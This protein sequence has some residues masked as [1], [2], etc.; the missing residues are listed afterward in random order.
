LHLVEEAWHGALVAA[1]I[2]AFG[3]DPRATFFIEGMA[4]RAGIPRPDLI[5]IHPDLGVLV[6]ENKGIALDDIQS[7]IG[8]T[9]WVVRDG[10]LKEEDPFKQAN[11]V[12]L[13]LRDLCRKRVGLSEVLFWDTAALPRISREEFER[14]FALPWPQDAIFAET[15][16]SPETLRNHLIHC[17]AQSQRKTGRKSLLTQRAHDAVMS[18]LSGKHALSTPRRQYIAD[19]DE[20]LI[21]CAG[22]AA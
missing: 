5:I 3:D 1:A 18:I 13:R 9:L 2:E 11:R 16:T 17:A 20:S 10:G 7:V 4:P 6:I 14:R 12:A 22:A 8:S 19:T 15:L 21:G